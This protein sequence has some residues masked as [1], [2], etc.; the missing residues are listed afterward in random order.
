MTLIR[1]PLKL[2]RAF[3]GGGVSHDGPEHDEEQTGN[4]TVKHLLHYFLLI[5]TFILQNFEIAAASKTHLV[6]R[7]LLTFLTH[8]HTISAVQ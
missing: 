5:K 2:Y 4:R 1:S 8:R 7:G 3:T 6:S